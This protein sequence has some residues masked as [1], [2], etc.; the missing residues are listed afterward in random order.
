M[1][2]CSP[3]LYP[4]IAFA[5]SKPENLI[6]LDNSMPLAENTLIS[7]SYKSIVIALEVVNFT[8]TINFATGKFVPAIHIS[9]K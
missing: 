1:S 7:V 3:F 2:L 6:T 8:I 4:V 5:Q 9:N